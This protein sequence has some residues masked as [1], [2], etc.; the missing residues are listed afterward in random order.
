VVRMQGGA[1]FLN[2]CCS[3]CVCCSVVV[4]TLMYVGILV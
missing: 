2:V 3:V 1:A 4:C